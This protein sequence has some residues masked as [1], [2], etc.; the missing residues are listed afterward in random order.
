MK[1]IVYTAPSTLEFLDV[2]EPSAGPGESLVDVAAVG[3][4]GSELHGI[5]SPG[6]RKPPL[7]MGHE[8]AGTT[9]EGRRVVVHP[10]VTCGRCDVCQRGL[11]NLCRNRTIVGIHIS[12]GFGERV[13]IPDTNLYDIPD[14]MTWEQAALI[15]PLANAVHAWRLAG[16]P[17]PE[18][19]GI[20]GSGTIGLCCLIVARAHSVKNVTVTDLAEERL[21][22]ALRLGATATGPQL[23]GEYDVIFDAVGLAVTHEASVAHLRPGGSAIWLGLLDTEPRFDSL[24]LIRS[25][26]RVNGSFCYTDAD[27]RAAIRLA[28]DIDTE[29]VRNFPLEEGADIFTQ[30]MNGRTDVVKALLRPTLN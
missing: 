26:K 5:Q 30:L 7:V 29:W 3:I 28:E 17:S 20:L 2:E 4:C 16:D 12:G 18:R 27:F 11:T 14:S 23:N 10:V 22:M 19:V 1:A 24:D 15:E 21:E 13:A 25:E 6:F 8:L 9:T